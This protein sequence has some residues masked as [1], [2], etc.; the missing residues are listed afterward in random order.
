MDDAVIFIGTFR[1]PSAET[2]LPA[3]EDMRAFV[4]GNVPRARSFHAYV[5]Q[6]QT[7]GTVMYEHPDAASLDEHLRV[8]AERIEAGTRMVDVLRIEFLGQP[9]AATIERLGQ[10]PAPVSVKRHLL[11]F[12][13]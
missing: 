5:N 8:A 12:T 13:R 9:S 2:W 3:I 6:D 1:I 7:E 4:E 11:G 10:Q